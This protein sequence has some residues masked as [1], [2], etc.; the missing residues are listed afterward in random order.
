MWILSALFS[1]ALALDPG[2]S[3]IEQAQALALKKNRIEAC[4]ILKRA[5]A[6]SSNPSARARLRDVLA[7]ISRLPFTDKG[8]RAFESGQAVLFEN[9]DLALTQ[10]KDALALEDGNLGVRVALAEVYILKN[11]LV[12]ARTELK[13]ARELNPHD[14]EVALLDVRALLG[15][16]NFELARERLKSV[17]TLDR[18]QEHFVLYAQAQDYLQQG[19]NARAV[20][21][22]NRVVAEFPK[23][24]EARYYLARAERPRAGEAHLRRY[25][26]LCQALTA[27]DRRTFALEPHACANQK[28]AEDELAKKSVD[29]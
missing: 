1:F 16:K 27:R 11:D 4:A 8:Q 29:L 26:S 25:V 23:F 24:P 15:Q 21:A 7:K 9:P 12:A 10:L 17:P 13:A 19:L 14:A 3:A 20:D 2:P 6:A 5:L 18:W 28:E 22:L